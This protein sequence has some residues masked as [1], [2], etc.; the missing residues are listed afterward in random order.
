M[1]EYGDH[2]AAALTAFVVEGPQLTDDGNGGPSR[3]RYS[4]EQ[5]LGHDDRQAVCLP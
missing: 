3:H 5:R 4:M 2:Q 1:G